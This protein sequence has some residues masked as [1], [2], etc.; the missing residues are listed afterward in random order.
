MNK[1]EIIAWVEARAVERSTWVGAITLLTA[2]G[3]HLSPADAAAIATIGAGLVG[4]ILTLTKD[5]D[6]TK[7]LRTVADTAVQAAQ[8]AKTAAATA[9]TAA[10]QAVVSSVTATMAA[11]AASQV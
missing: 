7:A 5:H 10:N 3:C 8:D 11:K 1:A 6:P 4:A 9:N 2:F